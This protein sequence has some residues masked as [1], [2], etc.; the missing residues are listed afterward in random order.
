[1]LSKGAA[2]AAVAGHTLAAICEFWKHSSN[3][4]TY[5]FL[6]FALLFL[7]V[8]SCNKS[9][10][11]TSYVPDAFKPWSLFQSGSYW[12]YLNEKKHVNDSTYIDSPPVSWFE[13][14]QPVSVQHQVISYVFLNSFLTE[15]DILSGDSNHAYMG[16]TDFVSGSSVLTLQ[17]VENTTNLVSTTCKVIERLDTLSINHNLFN[18]VIHTRDTNYFLKFRWIKDYYFAKNIGLLKF[19]IKTPTIDST[20][21]ILRWH[22]NQ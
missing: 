18:N 11:S 20:W 5:K 22:V 19:K 13:P 4:K 14:P 15:V 16:Y 12:V 2:F 6:L 10:T 7:I 21:S 8:L 1:M 17:V 3:M 9:R